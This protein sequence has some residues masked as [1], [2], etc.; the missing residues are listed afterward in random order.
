M[1]GERARVGGVVMAAARE[2]H[3]QARIGEALRLLDGAMHTYARYRAFVDVLLDVANA[4]RADPLPCLE[5]E[6]G[7]VYA[8]SAEDD[9]IPGMS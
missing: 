8:A 4:L 1:A 7:T 5:V 2:A 6:A 9:L 3:A